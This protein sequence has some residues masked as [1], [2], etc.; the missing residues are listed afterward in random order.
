MRTALAS[1]ADG[2]ELRAVNG[3]YVIGTLHRQD[4]LLFQQTT[5]EP[6]S[7]NGMKYL[8]NLFLLLHV[9]GLLHLALRQLLMLLIVIHGD[10]LP[11]C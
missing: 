6:L 9:L 8:I 3:L 5:E 2:L 4:I 10:S 11:A 1:S 7:D